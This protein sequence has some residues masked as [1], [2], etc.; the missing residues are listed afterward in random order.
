MFRFVRT[1]VLSL[2]VLLG[3]CNVVVTKT[4]L[5]SK[6]DELGGQPLRPGLWRLASLNDCPLDDSKPLIDW[7]KCA[8]GVVF[9]DG[10]AGFYERESETPVWTTQAFVLTAGAPRIAQ[11]QAKISGGVKVEASPYVY[12]GVKVTKADSD[13]RILELSFWPVQCG[14]PA[15]GNGIEG[16]AKPLPGLEMKPGEPL[17]TTTSPAALRAAAK[18]SE[19]WAPKVLTARWL[20]DAAR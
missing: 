8:G 16:T 13:G 6:A 2:S 19:P 5:F 1:G 20:R 4:P 10:T 17:C 11:L 3:A 12:A 9:K 18:A 14:P 7:P 15:T